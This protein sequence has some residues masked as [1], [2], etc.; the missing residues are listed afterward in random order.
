[1]HY[2]MVFKK[3]NKAKYKN[4]EQKKNE[5]KT[6]VTR[7]QV[8]F[9]IHFLM[10]TCSSIESWRSSEITQKAMSKDALSE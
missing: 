6:A 9:S 8:A 3:E 2:A 1:M 10:F 4:K 7:E 5:G